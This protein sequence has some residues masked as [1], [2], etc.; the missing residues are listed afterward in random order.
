LTWFL[1]ASVSWAGVNSL[2]STS[3]SPI[4]MDIFSPERKINN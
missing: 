2:A 4:L 1:R 3:I